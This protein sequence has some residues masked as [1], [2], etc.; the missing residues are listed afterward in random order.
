[1]IWH[2]S[3]IE[4]VKRELATDEKNGLSA[5]EVVSRIQHYGENKY[6]KQ[7]DK[8]MFSRVL[9]KL[10]NALTVVMLI[11]SA[12]LLVTGIISNSSDWYIPLL[13]L[14]V[15]A[16]NTV[17][18]IFAE[19][20]IEVELSALKGDDSPSARVKRDGE[21]AL[22]DAAMLVPGDIV[23]LEQGD[24]IPADGRLVDAYSLICDE[25]AVSGDSA[26]QEKQAE[27]ITDDICPLSQRKNMVYSGC[28]VTYGHATMIV[29]ETGMNT[30]LGRQAAIIEQTEGTELPIHKRLKGIGRTVSYGVMAAAVLIFFIGLICGP[31]ESESFS[32]LVLSMLLT[33]CTVALAALPETLPKA[34][35][36]A[37]GLGVR[38]LLKRKIVVKNLQAIEK[39]ADTTV[40]IS[41]KTGTLTKNRMQMSSVYDG[42]AIIDLNYDELSEN[43][44]TII[45]TGALCCN[46]TV[47]IAAG[48][49]KRHIGD[50]TEAGIVAA[51]IKYCGMSKEDIENIYPR[52]AE[53][54]FD[55]DRKLMT[56]INM[57][58][59]RPFAVVKGAPDILMQCCTGAD[60]TAATKAA[61]EMGE[62]GLRVIAVGIKPLDEIPANPNPDNMERNLSLLGLFGMSDTISL[63]TRNALKESIKSGIRT[64]MITGDHITT[65][66]ASA[67]SLGILG[68]GEK[69]ITGE[70]LQNMSDEELSEKIK[71]I[72]VYSRVSTNDKLRIVTAWQALG[73]VVALTGDSVDDSLALKT[74]DV[75]CAMG[76][77]GTDIAKGSAD[78]LLTEDSYISIVGAIL[79]S[80][81]IYANIKRIVSFL[82]SS[83][84]GEVLVMLLGLIIFGASPLTALA[85]LCLNLITDFAPA[86][87]MGAEPAGESIKLVK[88]KS[89]RNIFFGKGYGIS[90]L[91]QGALMGVLGLVAFA[92]GN[93]QSFQTGSAMAFAVL[94][95]SQSVL[96]FSLRSED[97]LFKAG[98]IKNKYMLL[99]L[100]IAI[101]ITVLLVATPIRIAF[102]LG[103][104]TDGMGWHILWLSLMPFVVTEAVKW[105]R[106]FI[107]K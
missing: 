51:C 77:T 95:L 72:S 7:N 78:I 106:F 87:A 6:A 38:R 79:E 14:V 9:G 44:L 54:P 59:N 99:S 83:N 13:I 8:N 26:P 25:S 105:I 18:E 43:A 96:A 94:I 3:E 17:A 76:V 60:L 1:M 75:G 48:G 20:R 102:G 86:L 64:V 35:N 66:V 107:K 68:E 42:S 92:L 21:V 65:A 15:L 53:V 11:V 63:E 67:K 27:F 82:L 39:L 104:V 12:I 69:A 40:I 23:L 33:S 50:P 19:H 28:S 74:A 84:L 30:E 73:E 98:L 34:V 80:K 62:R 24:Y 101:I 32:H 22:V 45:R 85:I 97:S 58:N 47:N 5:A 46:A 36:A 90:I 57:I 71:N 37:Y 93:T 103:V 16:V 88:K 91:W 29:T 41:D 2:S 52:M 4:Q 10:S 56:T 55:S 61:D 100:A 70:E 89:N 31:A 81:N 49:K